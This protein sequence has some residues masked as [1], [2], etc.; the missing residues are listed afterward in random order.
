MKA[1]ALFARTTIVGGVFFL[2]PIVVLIVILANAFGFAKTGLQAIVVHIPRV[3]DLS[4]GVATSLSIAMIAL[5]CLLAGLV[6]NTLIA[7]RF[8]NALESSVLSK[9]PAYEYL[10][11]ESASALGVAEI[12][13]LPVVFV[14]MEGGWQLGVQTEALSNGFVSIFVPGA[15][16]PHSGSVF[17]FSTDVVRPA[18]IKLA[19]GLPQ[20]MR[21]GRIRSRRR[22]A[23]RRRAGIKLRHRYGRNGMKIGIVGAGQVGATAAYSM[24]MRRVGSEIVLVDRNADLAVAQARDIL[25]A[26]P[27]ADPVRVRAGEWADLDGARLVVLAAGTNQKP[28]ESRL[29]LLSRNAEI[30]AG[31]VPAVLAAS[32]AAIFLVATNPVDVMTQIV[33]AIAG[34]GGVASERVIGSGTILD[35][36]RFRT[37]LAA[38]LGISPT[39]IDARVLGEHGDSEVLHWSGAAAGN[40]PVVEVARQMG[41]RLA[42]TDRS[43]IDTAVRRAAGRRAARP[44]NVGGT[45]N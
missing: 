25:D 8:V 33:T 24:M 28:G 13:E 38:H 31:I 39:Y 41:R 35:S 29:D 5:V 22:L 6:A 34:R 18:G 42:E 43:R 9:I 20:A 3:S 30:F 45:K 37:L 15:P 26:T 12:G 21:R 16:N 17:F 23:I 11:Q 14:P 19:A 2:A 10:K 4:V 40:L 32:P 27:F 1:I 7:Q 44:E 36:A